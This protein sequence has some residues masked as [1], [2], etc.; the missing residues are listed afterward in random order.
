M[1]ALALKDRFEFLKLFPSSAAGIA[2]VLIREHVWKRWIG[3]F[4][5]YCCC[6]T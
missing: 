1:R 5:E 3:W 2:Y 6:K 4:I